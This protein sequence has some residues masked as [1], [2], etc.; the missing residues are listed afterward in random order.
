MA[1]DPDSDSES[2]SAWDLFPPP[3]PTVLAHF[4]ELNLFGMYVNR[5]SMGIY[6]HNQ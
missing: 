3:W 4:D 2:D 5:Q 1:L 6:M